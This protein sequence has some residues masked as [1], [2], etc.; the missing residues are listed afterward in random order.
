MKNYIVTERTNLFETNDT[1]AMKFSIIGKVESQKMKEA[2]EVA[3]KANE[4]LNSKIVLSNNE[5]TEFEIQ[6]FKKIVK[7]LKQ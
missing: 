1:I 3:V 6:R 7:E 5:Y 4:T 2:F